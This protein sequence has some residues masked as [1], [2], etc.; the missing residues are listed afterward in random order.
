MFSTLAEPQQ[1][2]TKDEHYSSRDAD[3]DRPGEGAGSR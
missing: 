3:D 2:R 1:H